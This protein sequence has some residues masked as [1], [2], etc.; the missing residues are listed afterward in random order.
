M[1]TILGVFVDR[2][3]GPERMERESKGH[4]IRDIDKLTPHLPL[5]DDITNVATSTNGWI[6]K[7]GHLPGLPSDQEIAVVDGAFR[8]QQSKRPS[9]MMAGRSLYRHHAL[10]RVDAVGQ[11]SIIEEGPSARRVVANIGIASIIALGRSGQALGLQGSD[12]EIV[13]TIPVAKE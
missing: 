11:G 3:A 13:R 2:T 10:H 1:R 8:S 12:V 6:I 9:F 5:D 7:C 4:I